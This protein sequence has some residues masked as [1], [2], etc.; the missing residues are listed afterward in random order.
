VDSLDSSTLEFSF[1]LVKVCERYF[2]S[3][4][5]YRH[6]PLVGRQNGHLACKNIVSAVSEGSWSRKAGPKT[7]L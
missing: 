1:Y 6:S 3:Y 7:L 2:I 4:Y 5:L